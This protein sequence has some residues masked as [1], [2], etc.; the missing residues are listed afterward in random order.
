MSRFYFRCHDVTK[1]I[2]L[3]KSN[4]QNKSKINQM[5][6]RTQNCYNSSAI[7]QTRLLN[8]KFATLQTAVDLLNFLEVEI[9]TNTP[10]QRCTFTAH[11]R[12]AVFVGVEQNSV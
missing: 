3:L 9:L 2:L 5:H 8:P 11:S 6:A 1:N 12:L 7:D 10:T 4:E